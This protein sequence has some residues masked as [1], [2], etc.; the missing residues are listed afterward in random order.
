MKFWRFIILEL[1]TIFQQIYASTYLVHLKCYQTQCTEMEE[2]CLSN[3]R[4]LAIW[5]QFQKCQ[6]QSLNYE[7]SQQCFQKYLDVEEEYSYAAIL[8]KC[9]ADCHG[10]NTYMCNK[11]KQDYQNCQLDT[12][13]YQKDLIH[14]EKQMQS[15]LK[16][17][18]N[19]CQNRNDFYCF[20]KQTNVCMEMN[21][22]YS[23]Y[24]SNL[25][26]CYLIYSLETTIIQA[27]YQL[28]VILFLYFI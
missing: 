9:Y 24:L 11:F 16:Q 8:M 4:C 5:N 28:F 10:L 23:I 26:G 12:S 13:C 27:F 25:M 19:D 7:Q 18:I 22:K 6:H 20:Q 3:K 21:S 17:N 1:C 14:Y 15:C 2:Q